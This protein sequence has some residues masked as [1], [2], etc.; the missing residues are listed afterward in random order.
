LKE[1]AAM[2]PAPSFLDDL[3]RANERAT[4]AENDFRRDIAQRIEP[5]ED[6]RA[7]AFRR[8]NLMRAVAAVVASAESE[9]IAVA[10]ALMGEVLVFTPKRIGHS[11]E[12]NRWFAMVEGGK[13]V[14]GD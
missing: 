3:K 6:E 10:A 9:E 4:S 5:L 7:F 13:W 1:Q 12:K 2:T 11:F 8:F 14:G